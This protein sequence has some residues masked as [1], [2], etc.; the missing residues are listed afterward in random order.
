MN[1]NK[2]HVILWCRTRDRLTYTIPF[3]LAYKSSKLDDG[4]VFVTC[5]ENCVISKRV[6]FS[7]MADDYCG[8]LEGWGDRLTPPQYTRVL[9]LTPNHLPE[10]RRKSSQLYDATN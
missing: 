3:S 4:P 5:D 9:C 6:H 10:N 7:A 2:L 8:W 1:Y